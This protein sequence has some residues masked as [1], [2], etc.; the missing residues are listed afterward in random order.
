MAKVTFNPNQ[1]IQALS[2]S[3]GDITFRTMN[4]HTFMYRTEEP[5]LPKNATRKQRAQFRQ[6]SIVNQCVMNLQEQIP[7]I[8]KALAMRTTIRNRILRL[9][10][11][12]SPGVKAPT[13]LQAAIMSAYYRRF[14]ETRPSH[15]RTKPVPNPIQSRCKS[16]NRKSS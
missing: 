12:L 9:Y 8:E 15:S 13:K 3:I 2:G 11:L 10:K 4:G 6:R 14:C 16:S 1:P 5:V 7:D